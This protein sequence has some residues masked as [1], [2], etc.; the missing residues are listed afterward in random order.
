MSYFTQRRI[1]DVYNDNM[2]DELRKISDLID[3][4]NYIGMV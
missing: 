4:Y 2:T 1:I 3:D